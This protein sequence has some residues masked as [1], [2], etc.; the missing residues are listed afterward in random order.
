MTSKATR[1]F[2]ELFHA[3]PA[4]VREHAIRNY[5]LWQQDPHHPS[6]RFRRLK[7]SRDRFTIRVGDD[8]RALGMRTA[9]TITWVWIGSHSDYDRLVS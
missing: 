4:N 5:E 6:L 8:Y 9:D 3:L 1:R 7:G 2:W